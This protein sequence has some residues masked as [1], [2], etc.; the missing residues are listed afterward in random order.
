[1]AIK[2][3]TVEQLKLLLL[4]TRD[5][6][7]SR[8]D[9][10]VFGEIVDSVMKD[11]GGDAWRSY[12]H[13]ASVGDTSERTVIRAV[14]RLTQNGWLTVTRRGN[15]GLMRG[16]DGK[17]HKTVTAFL[18]NF[19]RVRVTELSP[20]PTDQLPDKIVTLSSDEV[21]S[22]SHHDADNV[23]SASPD[24]YLPPRLTK[25]TD[26]KEVVNDPLAGATP[27][28]TPAFAG[29]A[30]PAAVEELAAALGVE[31]DDFAAAAFRALAPDADAYQTIL[32]GACRDGAAYTRQEG[33]GA[34]TIGHRKKLS[35]WLREERWLEAGP[36]P[37][38]AERKSSE[39][40]TYRAGEVTRAE[41]YDDGIHL[42]VV[43]EQW[44]LIVPND[45]RD[46]LIAAIDLHGHAKEPGN[47]RAIPKPGFVG[48]PWGQTIMEMTAA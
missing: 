32:A 15:R 48:R 3:T 19:A 20:I 29:P 13:L 7:L 30:V 26:G 27:P 35:N 4:A 12:K 2:V 8:A 16:K 34:R 14:Q 25:P 43:G 6:H 18:P 46:A 41:D 31:V 45:R 36:R 10:A 37:Y 28:P 23:T 22:A 17:M 33:T 1:M 21:T 42:S 11:K 44:H 9:L 47:G 5:Q 24:S 39:R 38:R 40:K